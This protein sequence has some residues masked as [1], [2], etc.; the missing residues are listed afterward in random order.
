MCRRQKNVNPAS[1][2]RKFFL[3]KKRVLKSPIIF[4][5]PWSLKKETVTYLVGVFS[6]DVW[7][8]RFF[9]EKWR[10]N[11]DWSQML[12]GHIRN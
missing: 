7:E 9:S 4:E 5:R 1:C 8:S 3:S 2:W 6:T 11:Q 10:E 12:V